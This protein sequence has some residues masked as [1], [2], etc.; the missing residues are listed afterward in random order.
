MGCFGKWNNDE[1]YYFRCVLINYYWR[2]VVVDFRNL[3]KMKLYE[4]IGNRKK[5]VN[6]VRF[7]KVYLLYFLL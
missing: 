5:I 7:L 6:E 1:F 2:I 3:V 4:I